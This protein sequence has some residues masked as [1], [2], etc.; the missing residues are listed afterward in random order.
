VF[1]FEEVQEFVDSLLNGGTERAENKNI[2]TAG[3][4]R[5][6]HPPTEYE[7]DREMKVCEVYAVNTLCIKPNQT[8]LIEV[9]AEC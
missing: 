6:W 1:T 9:I 7:I 3:T 8:V 4:G 5:E 2:L